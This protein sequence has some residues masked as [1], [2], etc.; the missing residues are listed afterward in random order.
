M[1]TLNLRTIIPDHM[2]KNYPILHPMCS[3]FHGFSNMINFT[4]GDGI[5][6]YDSNEKKYMDFTSGLWNVNL[7][8]NHHLLVESIVKQLEKLP[9]CSLFEYT[10][11]VAVEAARSIL[12]LL[13]DKM[14]KIMYTCSGSESVELALKLMREY[15]YEQGKHKKNQ[16]ISLNSSYHGIN[17]GSMS[18]SGILQG[19]MSKYSPLMENITFC[20]IGE[21]HNC[22]EC[23]ESCV[24]EFENYL[25]I[26]HESIA[27]ILVEPVL[28]SK[29]V[30][31]IP[32]QVLKKIR[33][34]CHQYEVLLTFDEV[35]MG[36]YRSGYP[37]Y[38]NKVNVIPDI[39]CMSKGINSG[40]LPLGAVA[41][42]DFICNS[43]AVK[44]SINVHGS[45]QAGNLL[46][47]ATA[48]TAIEQ[49][50]DMNCSEIVHNLGSYIEKE[51]IKRLSYHKNVREVHR[52][53][54]IIGIEIT[55]IKNTK[56]Y[57]E[58][59]YNYQIVNMLLEHGLVTYPS[60]RGITILPMYI[61][62]KDECDEML[63]IIDKTF[64]SFLY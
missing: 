5:Y 26:N 37:F 59:S 36:F 2:Y 62:S 34:L 61:T 32:E 53:G 56:L 9:F 58:E 8:Y 14:V 19:Y 11:E 33:M 27:G 17:Y 22:S 1:N 50:R 3:I 57:L 46:S 28:A 63:D 13:P 25:E 16:I 41:I 40:Y 54:F 35:A 6:L 12:D 7:G 64:R 4:R 38:M 18:A 30:V 20:N 51:L 60:E 23:D 52:A 29:G 48:I 24:N 45:T 43:M 21:C 15:W 49:Y 10:N 42:C 44:K 47:C 31:I 39:V 55:K